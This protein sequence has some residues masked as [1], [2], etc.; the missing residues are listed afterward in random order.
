M[1]ARI[2]YVINLYLVLVWFLLLL[3]LFLGV[4]R[5]KGRRQLHILP[6]PS[7]YV[8]K[9]TL[10]PTYQQA[11]FTDW[12]TVGPWEWITYNNNYSRNYADAVTVER[13]PKNPPPC[14]EMIRYQS[15]PKRV[16][17]AR[18]TWNVR[19]E[20]L[21]LNRICVAFVIDVN[22]AIYSAG[23][24]RKYVSAQRRRCL[25]KTFLYII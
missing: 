19:C 23:E 18:E 20:T 17:C 22:A 24:Q 7:Q 15:R 21:S 16:D 25:H 11:F 10:R 3:H 2:Q 12:I 14:C 13:L 6:Q 4:L 9:S 5:N 8:H 1:F